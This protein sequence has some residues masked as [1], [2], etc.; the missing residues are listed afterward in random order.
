MSPRC[1]RRHRRPTLT[2]TR[3]PSA[4]FIAAHAT[5]S[6]GDVD[7]CL[8][9]EV[10]VVLRDGDGAPGGRAAVGCLHHIQRCVERNGHAVVVVAEGAGEELLG[11]SVA[12]DA[13]GN[14]KLPKIGAFLK[15]EIA[16][17]FDEQGTP[18]TIKYAKGGGAA[19]AA[20]TSPARYYYYTNSPR[21]RYIDPS[22]M[23]RSGPANA[24]DAVLC[25]IL[26]QN[27]VHGAS[28]GGGAVAVALPP[29]HTDPTPSRR[30][31]R[32]YGLPH[33]PCE[34]PCRLPAYG[35]RL[36]QL[37]AGYERHRPDVGT[38]HC[39]DPPAEHRQG[40]RAWRGPCKQR[41]LGVEPCGVADA[42][43]VTRGFS[44]TPGAP[45]LTWL[46]LPLS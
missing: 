38:G 23:V 31:G 34:Q 16:S 21:P 30:H 9:P 43:A 4:G 12:A 41:R 39:V 1:R 27:A 24:G 13:G 33:R 7:L 36:R 29:P 18:A 26:A 40:R 14:R 15:D 22:Y 11:Q 44:G 20:A 28:L 17:F 19:A 42:V 45:V 6:S 2:P 25:M 5:L 46:V 37:P 8:V 3:P 10:D 32:I 35:R